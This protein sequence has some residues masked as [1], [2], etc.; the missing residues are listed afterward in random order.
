MPTKITQETSLGDILH[1]WTIQEY[2][3]HDRSVLWYVLM[4]SVALI[5]VIYA[6]VTGNFLFALVIVLAAIILFLQSH[7]EP[8]QLLSECSYRWI[9]LCELRPVL[10]ATVEVRL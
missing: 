7:Q 4:I 8:L 3:R 5:L 6:V 2:E 9:I 1:R 10:H